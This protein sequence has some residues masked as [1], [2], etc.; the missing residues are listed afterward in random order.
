VY[1]IA[2][3]LL[4]VVGPV[5]L[6]FQTPD[7]VSLEFE[8][9][10]I[11]GDSTEFAKGTVYYQ[12]PQKVFIEVQD[13][14]SQIMII[15]GEVMLIYYP[16]EKKAFRIKAKGPIPIPFV[17]SILSVMKDDCGLTEMGY[18]LVKHEIERD[19]LYTH[20][21]PPR[22]LKKHLGKFIL[23]TKNGL[24]IYA[25]ARKPDGK[26]AAKSFYKKHTKLAGKYFPLEVRS[27]IYDG[28]NRTEEYVAYSDVKLNISLPDRIVN[29][30]LPDSIPVRETEW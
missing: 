11:Q 16:I 6:G 22:K 10:V 3:I 18:T 20:W 1:V 25:E 13:P 12:A 19:A 21:A 8:R 28:S 9:K 5:A 29:F 2:L 30:K 24:L 4:L 23:G 7:T 27:E 17:Q 15:D 26:T 14:I